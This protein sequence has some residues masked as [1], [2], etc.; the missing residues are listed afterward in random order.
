TAS[1]D[2]VVARWDARS[3]VRTSDAKLSAARQRTSWGHWSRY[4]TAEGNDGRL[5]VWD[6]QRD[7]RPPSGG[8][9]WRVVRA[10]E[11]DSDGS[12]IVAC[13]GSTARVWDRTGTVVQRFQA[14]RELATC[15]LD[16]TGQRV[17]ASDTGGHLWT[18]MLADGALVS[19]IAI[20]APGGAFLFG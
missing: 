19:D 9:L 18:W 13:D 11:V 1:D 10:F 20:A 16:S 15:A 8:A 14:S 6:W 5:L 12:R 4:V 3:G 2:G 17:L 7:A